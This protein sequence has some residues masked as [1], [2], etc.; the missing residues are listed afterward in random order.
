M[1]E[2]KYV[3]IKNRLRA[4]KNYLKADYKIHVCIADPCAD[5]CSVHA[6]STTDPDYKGSCLHEHNVSCDR[7]E[8]FKNAILDIQ[9]SMASPAINFG[10]SGIQE[11]IQHDF[12]IA[13]PKIDEWK[14]HILRTA[15]QDLGFGK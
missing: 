8:S 1:E 4:A 6:L 5:H 10:G 9:L 13:V 3:D 12:D 7:C 11:E 15:H 14:T 2:N